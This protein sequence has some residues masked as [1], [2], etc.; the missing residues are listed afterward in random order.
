MYPEIPELWPNFVKKAVDLKNYRNPIVHSDFSDLPDLPKLYALFRSA[1][2]LLHPFQLV[3]TSARDRFSAME[4]KGDHLHLDIDDTSYA[5]TG[6]DCQAE[7]SRPYRRWPPAHRF[8]RD[9]P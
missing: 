5:F 8:G 9:G 4:W 1:N 6:Q 2:E 3:G 7:R